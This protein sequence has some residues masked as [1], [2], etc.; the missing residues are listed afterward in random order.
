MDC[1][2]VFNPSRIL[3][4]SLSFFLLSLFFPL[5]LSFSLLLSF[6]IW[7]YKRLWLLHPP[8]IRPSQFVPKHY[9]DRKLKRI[10]MNFDDFTKF[11]K[12]IDVSD[13]QWVVEWWHI[14][15]TINCSFKDN[16]I[17]LQGSLVTVK[18][19]LAMWFLRY[20]GIYWKDLGQNPWKLVMKDGDQRHP[21]SSIPS[22]NFRV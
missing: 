17:P 5:M 18:D 15:G 9:R 3:I 6:Q 4:S 22:S 10:E 14:L 8:I 13:I 2:L 1:L 12:C 21:L 11:M 20:F 16:Y 19:L 7:L